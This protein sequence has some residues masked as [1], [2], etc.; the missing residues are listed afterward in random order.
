MIL[1]CLED[2]EYEQKGEQAYKEYLESGEKGAPA[3]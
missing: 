1:Q 2:L 3:K